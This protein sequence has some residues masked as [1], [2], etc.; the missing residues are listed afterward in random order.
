MFIYRM[1]GLRCGVLTLKPYGVW[2]FSHFR[3]MITLSAKEHTTD[4]TTITRIHPRGVTFALYSWYR[5]ATGWPQTP[6]SR[7][8]CVGGARYIHPWSEHGSERSLNLTLRGAEDPVRC[9]MRGPL[10]ARV[11]ED[12]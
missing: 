5:S 11:R 4:E 6:E 8:L 3:P 9:V 7:W 1:Y 10:R 2:P 12:P